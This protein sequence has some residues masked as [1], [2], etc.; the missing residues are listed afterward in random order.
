M[1][2]IDASTRAHKVERFLVD[3]EFARM[4]TVLMSVAV[5]VVSA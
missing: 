3:R 1:Q 5:A 2:V 4:D